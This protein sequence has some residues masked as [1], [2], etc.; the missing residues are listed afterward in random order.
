VRYDRREWTKEEIDLYNA[1][2]A[3]EYA[4]ERKRRGSK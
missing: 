2:Y 1:T 3:E 4:A